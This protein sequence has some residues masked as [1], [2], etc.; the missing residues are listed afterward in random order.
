MQPAEPRAARRGSGAR[1]PECRFPGLRAPYAAIAGLRVLEATPRHPEELGRLALTS[2]SGHATRALAA[3]QLE[4]VAFRLNEVSPMGGC[5]PGAPT[6]V[7]ALREVGR[8]EPR[9]ATCALTHSNLVPY[10][11]RRE[12]RAGKIPDNLC[13]DLAVGASVSGNAGGSCRQPPLLRPRPERPDFIEDQVQGR[14]EPGLHRRGWS[15]SPH[16]QSV[17]TF[18][19]GI[20]CPLQ[21][22]LMLHLAAASCGCS[23]G[24]CARSRAPR[25]GQPR[26]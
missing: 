15:V 14:A 22:L 2:T 25:A 16:G 18:R 6:T 7:P 17:R 23:A 19:L 10:G 9:A 8:R 12:T 26:A 1:P 4:L 5:N 11:C 13:P 3:A 24:A 20:L 21:S